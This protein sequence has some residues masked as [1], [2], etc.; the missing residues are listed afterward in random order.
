M[1]LKKHRLLSV[2]REMNKREREYAVKG[3]EE[4]GQIRNGERVHHEE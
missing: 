4:K 2:E 1:Y 3:W